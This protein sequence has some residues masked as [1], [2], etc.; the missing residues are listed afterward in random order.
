[1]QLQ[2]KPTKTDTL[3]TDK[4]IA[5]EGRVTTMRPALWTLQVSQRPWMEERQSALTSMVL[6]TKCSTTITLEEAIRGQP[7]AIRIQ[8]RSAQASQR[9]MGAFL[10]PVGLTTVSNIRRGANAS[11]TNYL[12]TVEVWQWDRIIKLRCKLP[13]GWFHLRRALTQP[14]KVHRVSIDRFFFSWATSSLIVLNWDFDFEA[15]NRV[16]IIGPEKQRRLFFL[17][18]ARELVVKSQ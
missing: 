18:E 1:M 7:C 11:V 14:K 16:I 4:W 5:M 13:T 10:G 2:G 8:H 9:S 3:W 6:E 12:S 17:I 15:T